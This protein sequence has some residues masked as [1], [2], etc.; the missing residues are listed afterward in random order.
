MKY[1]DNHGGVHEKWYDAV[2]KNLKNKMNRKDE[3]DEEEKVTTMHLDDLPEDGSDVFIEEEEEKKDVTCE[4]VKY[5]IANTEISKII[6]NKKENNIGVID[7]D[8]EMISISYLD[9]MLSDTI[10]K[11][12][13]ELALDETGAIEDPDKINFMIE[14]IMAD[15]YDNI[16]RV[17]GA[18]S[19]SNVILNP[20]FSEELIDTIASSID[21]GMKKYPTHAKEDRK[22][23]IRKILINLEKSINHILSQN[24]KEEE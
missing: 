6:I 21:T 8:G 19:D 12:I 13:M 17:A 20:A 15:N 9:P 2:A 5:M 11:D 3:D 18:A 7:K 10:T 23:F 22:A 4:E 24:N 14:E 1:K 16:K